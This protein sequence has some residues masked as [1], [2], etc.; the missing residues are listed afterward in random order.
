M[1]ENVDIENVTKIII[2][3]FRPFAVFAAA[4]CWLIFNKSVEKYVHILNLLWRSARK[5]FF[6]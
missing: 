2:Y 5:E 6:G 3:N 1:Y 4:F